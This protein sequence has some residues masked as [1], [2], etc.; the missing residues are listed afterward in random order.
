MKPDNLLDNLP[1]RL[2]DEQFDCLLRAHGFQL[3]RIISTGHATPPDQWY[4]QEEDEWVLLLAGSAVLRF[5]EP[6]ETVPLRPGDS[7]LIPAR[8]LHRV[9]ST[10]PD[11]PTV[12]LALHYDAPDGHARMSC[13]T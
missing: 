7:L 4:D 3:E 9:E 10:D 12:W 8:R 11:T 6:D 1:Q 2:P 13:T 5:Q